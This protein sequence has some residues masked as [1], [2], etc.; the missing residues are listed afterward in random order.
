MKNRKHQVVFLDSEEVLDVEALRK[1]TAEQEQSMRKQR[2]GKSHLDI[3]LSKIADGELAAVIISRSYECKDS[4]SGTASAIRTGKELN[5]KFKGCEPGM[6]V[7]EV[8]ADRRR[9]GFWT[10]MVTPGPEM[11]RMR[12]ELDGGDE[13][14]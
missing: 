11:N 3:P 13:E 5:G 6:F 4:A 14:L 10:V 8:V 9:K 1:E 2:P 12:M 7:S